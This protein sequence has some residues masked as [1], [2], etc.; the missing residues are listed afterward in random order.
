MVIWL[1]TVVK[2]VSILGTVQDRPRACSELKDTGFERE[3]ALHPT[4]W[5]WENL[6]APIFALELGITPWIIRR[7]LDD[8]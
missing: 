5:D 6:C 2:G 7:A 3:A 8:C 4:S 1:M